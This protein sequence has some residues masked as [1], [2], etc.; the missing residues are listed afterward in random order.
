MMRNQGRKI[1]ICVEA[2]GAEIEAGD[3]M[4]ELAAVEM[5]NGEFTYRTYRTF[6]DPERPIDPTAEAV[7][8]IS[9]EWLV[10]APRFEEIAPEVA[11]FLRGAQLI[12]HNAAFHIGLLDTELRGAGQD[13][14]A[15]LTGEVIDTLQLAR[16]LRPNQ[17][18]DLETLVR[19]FA[20]DPPKRTLMGAELDACLVGLVYAE[21]IKVQLH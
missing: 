19:D 6:I 4:I 2:T 16:D 15:A 7:H 9:D 20:I 3:R 1:V 21:L 18:N 5:V 17:K 12:A 14:V 10:G 13:S 8:G 11:E